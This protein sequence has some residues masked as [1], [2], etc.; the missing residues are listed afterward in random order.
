MHEKSAEALPCLEN[1]LRVNPERGLVYLEKARALT[2]Q[3]LHVA[4]LECLD[5]AWNRKEMLEDWEFSEWPLQRNRAL[6]LA[7]L[8][9]P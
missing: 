3:G 5:E 8:K 9:R 2:Q 1:A 7:K 6:A 4:A